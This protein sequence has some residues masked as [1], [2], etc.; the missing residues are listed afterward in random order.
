LRRGALRRSPAL[1]V[2]FDG[3]TH[4][5]LVEIAAD[6]LHFQAVSRT[7][8]TVDSGTIA[9]DPDDRKPPALRR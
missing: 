2:G 8:R 3:D 9:R 7:G 4:F 6:A 1:A 5:L